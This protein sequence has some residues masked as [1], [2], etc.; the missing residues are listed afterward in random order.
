MSDQNF[1]KIK[2]ILT[3][4]PGIKAKEIVKQLKNDFKTTMDKSEVNSILYHHK[5]VFAVDTNY[6]WKVK[7]LPNYITKE[8]GVW[9]E[10]V[11]TD[12]T[13]PVTGKTG[14]RNWTKREIIVKVTGSG[15]IIVATVW[16]NRIDL[17]K[18]TS[19]AHVKMEYAVKEKTKTRVTYNEVIKLDIVNN[20]S[21]DLPF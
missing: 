17:L 18:F 5:E 12:I 7:E 9:V 10:G 3:K 15:E 13:S 1:E 21:D 14:T 11:V 16:N 4:S 20:K 8:S 19:G 2:K 6:S